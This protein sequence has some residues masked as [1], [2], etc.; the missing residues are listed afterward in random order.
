MNK[1]W[2]FC[3]LWWLNAVYSN[4]FVLVQVYDKNQNELYSFPGAVSLFGTPLT[5]TT[6]EMHLIPMIY[7]KNG[8]SAI[9]KPMEYGK[10]AIVMERG[11]CSFETKVQNAQNAGA[12]LAIV[13][14]TVLAE[15]N[16]G[17]AEYNCAFGQAVSHTDTVPSGDDPEECR[18]DVKCASEHCIL[19]EKNKVCCLVTSYISMQ[20]VNTI[21]TPTIPSLYVSI[22]D[23]KLLNTTSELR[24]VNPRDSPWNVSM[25]LIWGL[26]VLIVMTGSLY[27]AARE[28]SYSQQVVAA[29]GTYIAI[30]QDIDERDDNYEEPMTLTHFHAIGFVFMSSALL[31]L[32]YYTH[33]LLV[34]NIAFM[35]S[36]IACVHTVVFSRWM[37]QL[38]S[39][40]LSIC[41]G[42]IW[43]IHRH[44]PYMWILQDLFGVCL[45]FVFLDTTHL[46]N[47]RVAS[48]LLSVAF[49]YD[50]FFVYLSPYIFGSNVMI[51]VA[52]GGAN[53]KVHS[54]HF[55]ALYPSSPEC[56][57]E[58]MPLVLRI[59]LLF[60]SYSGEAML[61][62]GDIVL[63]GLLVSF[64]LRYD[65]CRGNPISKNYFMAASIAYAVGLLMANI[66]AVELR[67]IVAGQPALMYIVP[68]LLITV[69]GLAKYKGELQDMWADPICM[70]N[71][72]E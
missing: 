48:I 27:S 70:T 2:L 4:N 33:I 17:N 49:C 59:P 11:G 24:I 9:T 65:Y 55:C 19:T 52:S 66:M 22:K 53:V 28:R 20:A 54:R 62:L 38:P 44:D 29:G 42:V 43:F 14:D 12:S 64:A 39:L 63:P 50:V 47:L 72:Q 8:C 57:H 34:V 36:A 3:W 37:P 69:L 5:A 6:T 25:F 51:A 35:L 23:G 68:S 56:Y 15:Y 7:P 26:A 13:A 71:S 67:H 31:L 1:Q 30:Q 16:S 60:S 61:G 10:Y 40:A 58:T 41:I 18:N 45:V 21:T 46:P 32:L